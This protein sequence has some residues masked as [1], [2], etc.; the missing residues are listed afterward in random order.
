MI[1]SGRLCTYNFCTGHFFAEDVGSDS[2]NSFLNILTTPRELR[3]EKAQVYFGSD[4][5]IFHSLMFVFHEMSKQNIITFT[6]KR[7]EG[8]VFTLSVGGS[9][10]NTSISYVMRRVQRE[11]NQILNN[12]NR[13]TSFCVAKKSI[14]EKNVETTINFQNLLERFAQMAT[15]LLDSKEEEN[16]PRKSLATISD[17][18]SSQ[19]YELKTIAALDDQKSLVDPRSYDPRLY[20]K[21]SVSKPHQYSS[22]YLLSVFLLGMSLGAL[23]LWISQNIKFFP[24]S[25]PKL[26][27]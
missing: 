3:D 14:F 1:S 7:N 18:F 22:G 8:D 12:I 6:I 21:Q 23:C 16:S 10:R 24:D 13:V 11:I 26:S 27:M 4:K 9:N 19:F 20:A 15:D 25:T 17:L 5:N 2:P